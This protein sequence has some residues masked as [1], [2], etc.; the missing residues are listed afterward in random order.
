[1]SL[2]KIS[3]SD[4]S[5]PSCAHADSNLPSLLTEINYKWL[6]ST[7]SSTAISADSVLPQ[8]SLTDSAAKCQLQIL[9]YCVCKKQNE[10]GLTFTPKTGFVDS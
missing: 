6:S 3:C 1:L 9:Y 2:N 8:A 4:S 5:D 10:P 7:R